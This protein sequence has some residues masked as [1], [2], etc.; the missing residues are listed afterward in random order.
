MA[1]SIA[2]CRSTTPVNELRRS[3]QRVSVEKKPATALSQ[4][5]EVGVKSSA[6]GGRARRAPSDACSCRRCL[7]S[8]GSPC[9]VGRQP[10]RRGGTRSV[11]TLCRWGTAPHAQ[12][13]QQAV[14]D[15]PR[16]RLPDMIDATRSPPCSPVR[17]RRPH[18]RDRRQAKRRPIRGASHRMTAIRSVHQR[19]HECRSSEVGEAARSVQARS[20]LNPPTLRGDSLTSRAVAP[21]LARGQAVSDQVRDARGKLWPVTAHALPAARS[22]AI[23][24]VT[25]PSPQRRR[26]GTFATASIPD[27]RGRRVPSHVDDVTPP[28]RGNSRGRPL[29]VV[30]PSDR[31]PGC[32]RATRRGAITRHPMSARQAKPVR[33][34][35][36]GLIR[37]YG[38]APGAAR[39]IGDGTESATSR[40]MRLASSDSGRCSGTRSSRPKRARPQRTG[41]RTMPGCVEASRSIGPRR[42][43]RHQ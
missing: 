39:V 18:K 32:D 2:D 16:P 14:P 21:G 5:S 22:P 20:K 25:S 8:R 33:S 27:H 38:A 23:S 26:R 10:R 34:E 41:R 35:R 31:R 12:D 6:S 7:G 4:G 42:Q 9:R 36:H 3:R 28:P 29:P 19:G 13:T 17:A 40:S 30:S 24:T 1:R 43:L 11:P 15:P 37:I